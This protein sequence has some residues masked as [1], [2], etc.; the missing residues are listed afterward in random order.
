[1]D[2]VFSC[3]FSALAISHNLRTTFST[4]THFAHAAP[5][6]PTA[7]HGWFLNHA[8]TTLTTV[9]TL[10]TE[11]DVTRCFTLGTFIRVSSYCCM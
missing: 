4:R 1:M 9:V 10:Q 5:S 8:D 2:A 6:P 11:T 3:R 7:R